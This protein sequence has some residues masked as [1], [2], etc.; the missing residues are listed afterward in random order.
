MDVA[1]AHAPL[2]SGP[3][4]EAQDAALDQLLRQII[5]GFFVLTDGQGALSKWSE[6]AEMLFGMDAEE[7]LGQPFFGRLVHPAGLPP[8][9]DGWRTFLE[10]GEVPGERGVVSLDAARPGGGTFALEAAFIPVK[11]DEGFD[12]SL[13]L[14]DLSFELPMDLMLLRM[15]QQ[16]PVVMK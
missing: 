4:P 14:E 2:P 7:A 5:S 11:L 13:F 6:P 10:M 3:A 8:L 12:F 1:T 16:H 15:R 9:A